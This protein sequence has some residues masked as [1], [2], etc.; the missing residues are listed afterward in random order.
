MLLLVTLEV[1]VSVC[2]ATKPTPSLVRVVGWYSF[3]NSN[4]DR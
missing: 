1:G 4:M 3:N 2:V